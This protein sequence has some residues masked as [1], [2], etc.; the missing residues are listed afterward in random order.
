MNSPETY[1]PVTF[2]AELLHAEI[3]NDP[4]KL[5]LNATGIVDAQ[6]I[7]LLN[8]RQSRYQVPADPIDWSQ[9]LQLIP[10]T[11]NATIDDGTENKLAKYNSAYK[12]PIGDA[13]TQAQLAAI[14]TGVNGDGSL[15]STPNYPNTLA[16][17][18]AAGLR[19]GSRVE[20]LFGVAWNGGKGSIDNNDIALANGS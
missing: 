13:H 10:V 17:V 20:W 19:N 3:V 6:R 4:D 14:L 8:T 2:S 18:T 16:A 11:E 9:F 7:P 1:A 15:K 12:I 5:G